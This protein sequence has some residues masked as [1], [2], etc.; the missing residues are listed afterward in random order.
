[1]ENKPY[2]CP[3]CR[4]NRTKFKLI[5]SVSQSFMKDAVTGEVQQLQDPEP[6]AQAEPTISCLVCGFAGNEQRYVKQA[7]REPRTAVPT[8]AVYR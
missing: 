5:S 6:V 3:N 8:E 1:M 2:F 4:S 7:E